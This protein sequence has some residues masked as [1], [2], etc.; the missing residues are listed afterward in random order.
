MAEIVAAYFPKPRPP[1]DDNTLRAVSDTSPHPSLLQSL[2]TFLNNPNARFTCPEQA[3][4]LELMV[5]GKQSILGIL[6][7]GTGKTTIIMLHAQLYGNGRITIVVL[8]LSGLRYD[9]ERRARGFYV[10]ISQWNPS[11]TF[12]ED[13]NIIYVSI[14]HLGFEKFSV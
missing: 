14:E 3:V 2:R 7:T 1:L 5:Q 13:A 11:G 12:N 8:P 6:G 10:S 4:L 9:L